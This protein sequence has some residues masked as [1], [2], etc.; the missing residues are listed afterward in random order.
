MW[1]QIQY[2]M[3]PFKLPAKTCFNVYGKKQIF[4]FSLNVFTEFSDT[5]YYM[6]IL[7]RLFEPATRH[8]KTQVP[9]RIFKLSP[10]HASVIYQIPWIRWI[11]WIS[12]LFGENSIDHFDSS[13]C[14]SVTE[15]YKFV[16]FLENWH[17]KLV[18]SLYISKAS[19]HPNKIFCAVYTDEY[20]M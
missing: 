19:Y 14:G 7:K 15:L 18:Y 1:T 17:T 8:S 12:D 20:L 16:F 4:E 9:E 2:S 13:T 5:K 3:V 10:I 6:H 11:H